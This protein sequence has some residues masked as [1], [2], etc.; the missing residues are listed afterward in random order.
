[1]KILPF[2]ISMDGVKEIYLGRNKGIEFTR[3]P[4]PQLLVSAEKYL[5]RAM[6]LSV[7]R[8]EGRN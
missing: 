7:D 3:E 6:A 2:G 5:A 1:M 8:R 4:N